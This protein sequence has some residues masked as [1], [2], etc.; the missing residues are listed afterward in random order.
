MDETVSD[1][2]PNATHPEPQFSINNVDS[3]VKVYLKSMNE[4]EAYTMVPNGPNSAEE[5]GPNYNYWLRLVFKMMLGPLLVLNLIG[6]GCP[7]VS[8][9]LK[10]F[11][12]DPR[13]NVWA[14]PLSNWAKLEL[15]GWNLH[16][17]M[18]KNWARNANVHLW[19]WQFSDN[20]RG[21]VIKTTSPIMGA[22]KSL[23]GS[24]FLGMSK[25][26]GHRYCAELIWKANLGRV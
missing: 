11:L 26:T 19:G 6:R 10:T 21:Y 13:P 18:G 20:H 23:G 12:S 9:S 25:N 24:T 8:I 1:L 2:E 3:K 5:N 14:N 7:L 16:H 17:T 4:P 22:Q 15:N